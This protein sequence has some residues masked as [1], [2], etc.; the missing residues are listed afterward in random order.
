MNENIEIIKEII[1]KEEKKDSVEIKESAKGEL[2]Y[3]LKIYGDADKPDE[4]IKK[5][6]SFRE[7]I[8]KEVLRR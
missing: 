7:R 6:N 1:I 5:I 8:E 4:F 2:Y 3:T